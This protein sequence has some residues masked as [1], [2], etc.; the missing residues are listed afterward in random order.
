MF[1]A[2][3]IE[4]SWFD[5][6]PLPGRTVLKIKNDIGCFNGTAA[7]C[8]SQING[9]ESIDLV[10]DSTGGSMDT[11]FTLRDAL[12]G[13][14]GRCYIT[15]RCMSAAIP[16]AIMVQRIEVAP[17]AKIMVHTAYRAIVG[18]SNDLREAA[19][20]LDRL[21]VTLR[22][23]LLARVKDVALVD[24]WLDGEDH[25]LTPTEAIACG[26]LD[27]EVTTMLT[28]EASISSER[29]AVPDGPSEDE[30]A[31]LDML[32]AFG[33]LQVRSREAFAREVMAWLMHN[34]TCP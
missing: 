34:T 21:T 32:R 33:P 20:S 18:R 22:E 10:I 16:L 28:P 24:R 26:L 11:A 31:L 2:P 1:A 12:S 3:V 15:G 9:A 8:L 19:D 5:V 29:A 14:V 4:H 6:L 23:V 25:Y 7:E 13:R 17:T 30:L 27:S